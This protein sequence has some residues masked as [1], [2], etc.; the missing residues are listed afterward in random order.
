MSFQVL[1]NKFDFFFILVGIQ[2]A[3]NIPGIFIP[4]IVFFGL[5][6]ENATMS[7]W[8]SF[9]TCSASCGGGRKTRYRICNTSRF[10]EKICSAL[11][12]LFEEQQCNV[13]NCNG[14]A[15]LT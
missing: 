6:S 11:G 8:S 12:P 14:E 5:F 2:F 1:P 4:T 7:D 13:H 15:L 10:G 3:L 9:T